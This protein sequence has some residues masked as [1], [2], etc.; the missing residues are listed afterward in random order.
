MVLLGFV[1]AYFLGTWHVSEQTRLFAGR[2]H[3]RRLDP[4]LIRQLGLPARWIEREDK[5]VSPESGI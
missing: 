2:A 4:A 3:L 5:T 1:L